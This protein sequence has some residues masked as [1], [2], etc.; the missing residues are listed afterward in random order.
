MSGE[1]WDDITLGMDIEIDDEE[2]SSDIGEFDD[3]NEQ[4]D[5]GGDGEA[6]AAAADMPRGYQHEPEPR[7]R[8]AEAGDLDAMA[9][10]RLAL[11]L[12]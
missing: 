2:Y 1:Y 8:Q 10:L 11:S 7:P 3:E 9:G 6:A 4:I 5:D 12:A